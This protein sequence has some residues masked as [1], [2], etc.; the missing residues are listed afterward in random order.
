[1]ILALCFLRTVINDAIALMTQS[2]YPR[3]SAND[4]A[5][6]ASLFLYYVTLSRKTSYIPLRG[7]GTRCSSGSLLRFVM[8][9]RREDC[10][11]PAGIRARLICGRKIL[12]ATV[13]V[14]LVDRADRARSAT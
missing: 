5:V 9:S 11:R 10:D 4:F 6:T 13:N 14:A 1:M 3:F 7:A 2:C 8:F 12:Q